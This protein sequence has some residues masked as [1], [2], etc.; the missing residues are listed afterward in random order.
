MTAISA[1]P[2]LLAC[3]CAAAYA[4]TSG[5]DYPDKPVPFTAVHV[6]D[7]FWAPRIEINRK[8]TIP[9]AFQKDEETCRVDLFVRAAKAL[10]GEPLENKRAPG[11]PFDD[12]DVYKV[13]EGAS[14]ALSVTPD[15]K[16]D[17]YVDGLIEKI[18]AAQESDGYLY[19]T[20]SID[21]LNPHRWAG[22]Q[23]WTLESVDSHELAGASSNA[24][25]LLGSPWRTREC[26]RPR[27][28]SSI[29]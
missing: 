4:Q 26:G 13:I 27:R 24:M 12:T 6:T 16:L 22:L 19:T 18:E 23:R 2:F 7:G 29:E 10:R 14:Y 11:Y 17:S 9:F 25:A 8:V 28:T 15:S 5:R 20:R 1:R 21:P 3:M